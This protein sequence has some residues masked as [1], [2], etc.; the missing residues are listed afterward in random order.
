M[1]TFTAVNGLNDFC[2]NTSNINFPF[3]NVTLS[4]ESRRLRNRY[5]K[6]FELILRRELD[7]KLKTNI[8]IRHIQII[9][10]MIKKSRHLII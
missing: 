3:L 10:Q 2:L 5:S 9:A 1:Q 6:T 8:T 4:Q 7:M